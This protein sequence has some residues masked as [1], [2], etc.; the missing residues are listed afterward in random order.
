MQLLTFA[1]PKTLPQPPTSTPRLCP[2]L[3]WSLLPHLLGG[4]QDVAAEAASADGLSG[5]NEARVSYPFPS[6]A[7]SMTSAELR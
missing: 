3:C 7:L 2:G 5:Q 1:S 6:Q 4:E